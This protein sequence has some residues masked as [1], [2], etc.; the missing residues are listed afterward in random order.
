M[1]P[2]R[3]LA[4]HGGLE[5]GP[6][7]FPDIC[8]LWRDAW[9]PSGSHHGGW[10]AAFCPGNAT[11]MATNEYTWPPSG[12]HHGAGGRLC[13]P[14][15]GYATIMPTTM[16][17]FSS[18]HGGWRAAFCPD[19][20]PLCRR[21]CCPSAPI[22]GAGGRLFVP[23]MRPSWRQGEHALLRSR[24]PSSMLIKETV[25]HMLPQELRTVATQMDPIQEA[26]EHSTGS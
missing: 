2:G 18:H 4:P 20:R 13:V 23:D 14:I 1:L 8:G 9:P 21:P 22:T 5:G 7:F 12:S 10:R 26:P 16:L 15:C 3:S 19:M 25:D 6:F 24:R 17:P 11:I